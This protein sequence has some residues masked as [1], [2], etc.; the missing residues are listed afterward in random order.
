MKTIICPKC[1]LKTSIVTDDVYNPDYITV[2]IKSSKYMK[3]YVCHIPILKLGICPSC[4]F[5]PRG[6]RNKKLSGL[7]AYDEALLEKVPLIIR[8]TKLKKIVGVDEHDNY[9]DVSLDDLK[10][11]SPSGMIDY[12]TETDGST[13]ATSEWGGAGPDCTPQG[14]AHPTKTR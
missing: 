3:G 1:G 7:N 10:D 9:V 14:A 6:E 4:F 5:T 2:T 11:L 13:M 12:L 8:D